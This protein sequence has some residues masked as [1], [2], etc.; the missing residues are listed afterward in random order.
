VQAVRARVLIAAVHQ[1]LRGLV[2][3]IGLAAEAERLDG[4]VVVVSPHLDDAVLS[5]GAAISHAARRG[6]RISV[7]TVLAGDPDSVQ[8][9]GRWDKQAGFRTAGQAAQV[10][11]QEDLRACTILGARPIWLPY[12][13][14]Q[15]ERGA[16]DA[17]IR[18]DVI[19]AVG[20]ATVLLPGFPL[21]HE[22]HVWLARLL[23]GTFDPTRCGYYVEQPYAA[24]WT[25]EVGVGRPEALGRVPPWHRGWRR[26]AGDARDRLNKVRACR[27]YTSQLPLLGSNAI[28]RICRREARLGGESLAWAW[29][30]E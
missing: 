8:V 14:H 1:R 29:E 12:F 7:L 20:E 16:D 9:P 3:W 30:G 21:M 11:R 26:A 27:A 15:Y 23:E 6:S 17:V 28:L 22:D 13:D 2:C 5:L 10:R 4:D 18:S 25:S 19:D 24:S